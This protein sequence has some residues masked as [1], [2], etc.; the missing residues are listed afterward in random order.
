M[1]GRY[2]CD[3]TGRGWRPAGVGSAVPMADDGAIRDPDDPHAL[4]TAP[5][6][7]GAGLSGGMETGASAGAA[8]SGPDGGWAAG[9]EEAEGEEATVVDPDDEEVAVATAPGSFLTDPAEAGGDDVTP[10][11]AEGAPAGRVGS[12]PPAGERT[13]RGPG[14][15]TSSAAG[16]GEPHVGGVDRDGATG[17]DLQPGAAERT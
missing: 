9:G 3:G 16:D 13:G 10:D 8:P 11:V 7:G 14:D 6:A 2:R 5:G 4:E 17:P 12:G 1:R 15:L